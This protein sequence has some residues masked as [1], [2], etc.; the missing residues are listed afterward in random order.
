MSTDACTPEKLNSLRI[1]LEQAKN[2][3]DKIETRMDSHKNIGKNLTDIN[4]N[5]DFRCLSSLNHSSATSLAIQLPAA[6][7]QLSNRGGTRAANFCIRVIP[8]ILKILEKHKKH[9]KLMGI[10][11]DNLKGYIREF[12]LQNIDD[13]PMDRGYPK[14]PPVDYWDLSEVTD[15][16]NLFNGL[17]MRFGDDADGFD[18]VFLD[19]VEEEE[20]EEIPPLYYYIDELDSDIGKFYTF[21]N[22]PPDKK[23]I[24]KKLKFLITQVINKLNVSNV[25]NME[26]MFYGNR[27]L[28][29]D[30]DLSN[31]NVSKVK[32]MEGMFRGST[33]H[34][35]INEWG[36]KT[37][38]VTTMKGMFRNTRY[39]KDNFH[40]DKWDV[41]NVTTME[42]MFRLSSFNGPLNKWHNHIKKVTNMSKMFF[43]A[44]KFNQSL[45]KWRVKHVENLDKMLPVHYKHDLTDWVL[46]DDAIIYKDET[47]N[48]DDGFNEIFVILN[49]NDSDNSIPYN[50]V[51]NHVLD[52]FSNITKLGLLPRNMKLETIPQYK[53]RSDLI[54]L[55]KKRFLNNVKAKKMLAELRKTAKSNTATKKV[56]EM[57]YPD[58]ISNVA[59][60]LGGNKTR[61]NRK[62]K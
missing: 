38:N 48:R 9:E 12:M 30:L 59:D 22:I 52:F 55:Y 27:F 62:N 8:E 29:G 58:I 3:L 13:L 49:E 2:E 40:L 37:E 4:K 34:T 31:W 54:E 11:N 46:N 7:Y 26:N 14:L 17:H 21:N 15:M 1:F 61:K 39:L 43:C 24:S 23:I 60:F 50:E 53:D 18:E 16:S 25:V 47:T 19:E 33:L 32:N 42:D 6:A 51:E 10:T 28:T 20:D 44:Y 56:L 45:D 57:K 41:S 36:K 5:I 35:S